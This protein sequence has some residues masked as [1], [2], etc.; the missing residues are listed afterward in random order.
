MT[1]VEDS[2]HELKEHVSDKLPEIIAA[3]ANTD[4]GEIIIGVKDNGTVIGILDSQLDEMQRKLENYIKSVEPAPPHRIERKIEEGKNIIVV[5][6][7]K[8]QDGFCTYKGVFYYRHGSVTDRLGGAQLK[9]FLASRN[10]I[11]FSS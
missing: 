3:F 11:Y 8:M 4:G 6:I 10:M 2:Y 9:D 7:F 1:Y 5:T